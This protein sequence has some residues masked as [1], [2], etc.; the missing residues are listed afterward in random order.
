MERIKRSFVAGL[1][2]VSTVFAFSAC[3]SGKAPAPVVTLDGNEITVNGKVVAQ[4]EGNLCP[5]RSR[6][7][8]QKSRRS[9][10][11]SS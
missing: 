6:S 7:L 1:L 2:C 10:T 5:G 8:P 11:V 9:C 3:A 4:T